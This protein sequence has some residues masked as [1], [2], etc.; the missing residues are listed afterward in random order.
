MD[1]EVAEFFREHNRIAE[2]QDKKLKPLYKKS[3]ELTEKLKKAYHDYSP[4]RRKSEF[5][6]CSK[7]GSRYPKKD[8]KE[9]LFDFTPCCVCGDRHSLYSATSIKR[10]EKLIYKLSEVQRLMDEATRYED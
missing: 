6:T 8:I 7:C 2:E 1:K 3:D 9:V 5:I 10:I 4:V